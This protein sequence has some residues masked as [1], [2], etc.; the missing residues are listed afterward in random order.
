MFRIS[1]EFHFSASHQLTGLPGG[2]Q[3]GRLHGHNYTVK[4]E[5]AGSKLN[6]HGFLIDYG[7][8]KFIQKYLDENFDHRHLN[9]VFNFQPTAELIAQHIYRWIFDQMHSLGM[10]N[11]LLRAVTVK[12]TEKTSA[13]YEP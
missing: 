9:D 6:R 7:E 3:C 1:K 11:A 8:M 13:R 2:H 10:D 12:E 5:F 4:V